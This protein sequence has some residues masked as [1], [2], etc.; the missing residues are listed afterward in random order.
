MLV[1]H[2]LYCYSLILITVKFNL[3]LI[4]VYKLIGK[5]LKN[6]RIKA[7]KTKCQVKKSMAGQG[8]FLRARTV[9]RTTDFF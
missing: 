3:S 1:E 5:T 6:D 8:R 9:V 2:E 7:A 4:G